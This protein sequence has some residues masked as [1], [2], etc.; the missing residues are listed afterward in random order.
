MSIL[1]VSY[2]LDKLRD[3][4]E[5]R[6]RL[7]EELGMEPSNS[8]SVM[9]KQQLS[10][11]LELLDDNS[12]VSDFQTYQAQYNDI[13]DNLSKDKH[14]DVELYRFVPMGE[15]VETSGTGEIM[16]SGAAEVTTSG[17]DEDLL[18]LDSNQKKVRFNDDLE[19]FPNDISPPAQIPPQT[20]SFQ[21]YHD[22]E[23]ENQEQ[24]SD[25]QSRSA[26][27]LD[28]RISNDELFARQQQQMLEQ[29]S[30][31]D[32]LASTVHS[33]HGISIEINQ[34]VTDQNEHVL[35]D[36]E[37]LLDS[38]SRNLDRAKRRLTNFS[39]AAR[40]NGPCSLIILLTIILIFLLAIL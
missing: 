30:H 15:T 5:E 17:S 21:P 19:T 27:Y 6:Q 28:E 25:Q 16:S 7:V 37:N 32:N 3:I 39:N 26:P 2:E 20:M 18:G 9:L 13:L 23:E 8:D 11:V 34:E 22:Y 40:E 35:D 24:E 14:V 4:V 1:K 36:L 33:T 31:L 29:D 38:S 12:T 10:I